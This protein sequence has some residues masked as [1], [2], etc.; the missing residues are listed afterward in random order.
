MVTFSAAQTLL[1]PSPTNTFRFFFLLRLVLPARNRSRH[2]N[3]FTR[4]ATVFFGL[5]DIYQRSSTTRVLMKK[6]KPVFFLFFYNSSFC[7]V[8]ARKNYL[9]LVCF[10][11]QDTSDCERCRNKKRPTKRKQERET[12]NRRACLLLS[13]SFI[14]DKESDFRERKNIDI[15]KFFCAGETCLE[16]CTYIRDSVETHGSKTTCCALSHVEPC[17]VNE[18]YFAE[19]KLMCELES[20]NVSM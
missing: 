15:D 11:P 13:A 14:S 8:R 16:T 2:Y 4:R 18:D 17:C 12:A 3:T 9:F 1:P 19:E 10:F 20:S 5:H 6:S 7:S